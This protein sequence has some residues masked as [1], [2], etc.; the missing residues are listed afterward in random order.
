MPAFDGRHRRELSHQGFRPIGAGSS[1]P[2]GPVMRMAQTP[3]DAAGGPALPPLP[4][5]QFLRGLPRLDRERRVLRSAP[6]WAPRRSRRPGRRLPRQQRRLVEGG[7]GIALA[8]AKPGLRR[9][10]SS[11]SNSWCYKPCSTTPG[12][13]RNK[14]KSFCSRGVEIASR[15]VIEVSKRRRIVASG[16]F[17]G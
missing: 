15:A 7:A 3:P 5:D 10:P 2:A 9:G 1:D 16:G 6:P 14:S 4:F 17:T 11:A 8:Y 13:P 12:Q